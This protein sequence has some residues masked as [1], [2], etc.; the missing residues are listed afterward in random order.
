VGVPAVLMRGGL[1]SS[2]VGERPLGKKLGGWEAAGLNAAP[3]GKSESGAFFSLNGYLLPGNRA[4]FIC[5]APWVPAL[6][7]RTALFKPRSLSIA[8]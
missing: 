5:T 8:R 6:I 7:R 1:R 3:L 4:R 2:L